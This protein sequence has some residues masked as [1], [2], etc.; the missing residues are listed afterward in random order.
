MTAVSDLRHWRM[1]GNITSRHRTKNFRSPCLKS[2]SPLLYG[3]A[4]FLQ[5]IAG[6]IVPVQFQIYSLHLLY[7]NA[8][9]PHSSKPKYATSL[10]LKIIRRFWFPDWLPVLILVCTFSLLPPFFS[11]IFAFSFSFSFLHVHV[12]PYLSLSYLM[13]IFYVVKKYT[14]CMCLVKLMPVFN[15][16]DKSKV[17]L[18]LAIIASRSLC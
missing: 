16:L 1:A 15:L 11:R 13:I 14:Y 3:I 10:K 12:Q 4:I 8:W 2:L 5:N 17:V 18:F 9:I 6:Q 7:F